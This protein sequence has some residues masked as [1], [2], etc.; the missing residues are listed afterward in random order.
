M[1]Q[2][3]ILKSAW[4]NVC[5]FNSLAPCF[6]RGIVAK[7]ILWL[8]ACVSPVKLR[9]YECDRNLLNIIFS[10]NGCRLAKYN[11]ISK[12]RSRLQKTRRKNPRYPLPNAWHSLIF[13]K[14]IVVLWNVL[15][16]S[17]G[18]K[19]RQSEFPACSPPIVLQTEAIEPWSPR[20]CLASEKAGP[21]LLLSL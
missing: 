1:H 5:Y 16:W 11:S 15:Q 12:M 3:L 17:S 14:K 21:S 4:Q 10:V 19:M 9:W 20:H 13:E 6:C 18:S 8:M 7:L 2:Y